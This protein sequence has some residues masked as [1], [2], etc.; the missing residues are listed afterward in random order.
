MLKTPRQGENIGAPVTA[1][2]T[3]AGDNLTYSLGGADGASFGIVQ[4][5]G[6]LQTN[7]ALDF[8]T[9]ASYTVVVTAT[10]PSGEEG[11]HHGDNHRDRRSCAA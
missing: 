11:H 8:D 3:D 4:T 1:T 6:Q 10:D 9:K 5:S 2:D 7:A